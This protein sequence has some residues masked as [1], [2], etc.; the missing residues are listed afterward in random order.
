MYKSIVDQPAFN[1]YFDA[2]SFQPV[3]LENIE[4]AELGDPSGIKADIQSSCRED[5]W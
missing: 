3:M 4:K 5:L 2:A 1:K